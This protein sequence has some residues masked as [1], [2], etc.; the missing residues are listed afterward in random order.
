MK[1]TI[2]YIL[3]AGIMLLSGCFPKYSNVTSA[4]Q[5]VLQV[6]EYPIDNIYNDGV[7]AQYP[8]YATGYERIFAEAN[9]GYY[10]MLNYNYLHFI[11]KASM[12]VIPVCPKPEC[13]H[14]TPNCHAYFDCWYGGIFFIENQLYV[15]ARENP[16]MPTE[17]SLIAV[18]P[19]GSTRKTV[20]TFTTQNAHNKTIIH[21]GHFYVVT[22][23]YDEEMNLKTGIWEYEINKPNKPPRFLMEIGIASDDLYDVM[24]TDLTAYGHYL[25]FSGVYRIG[26]LDLNQ[27]EK[28]MELLFEQEGINS[29]MF[30]CF[31]G[32]HLVHAAPNLQY[33]NGKETYSQQID[34]SENEPHSTTLSSLGQLCVG[35][36]AADDQYIYRLTLSNQSVSEEVLAQDPY[37]N[38]S[39]KIYDHQL[40]LVENIN[41]PMLSPGLTMLFVSPGE[42]VFFGGPFGGLWYINKHE[43]GSG[44][45][46]I[47][48]LSDYGF[49][50]E[51]KVY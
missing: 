7:D 1:K 28:G 44:N 46:S 38:C 5:P 18:S 20:V 12:T 35:G 26:R 36:M 23:Q 17:C 13:P 42:H 47:H 9:D 14:N 51:L 25:Y 48:K 43:I 49:W 10:V 15:V 30:L 31:A 2:I 33:E 8:W 19:D 11:D 4:Q 50:E 22:E 40:N 45:V 37:Y 21:R 29:N 41:T 27:P 24:V 39:L 16:S 32:N 34:M 6:K 3:L